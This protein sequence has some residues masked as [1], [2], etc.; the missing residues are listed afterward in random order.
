MT[1]GTAHQPGGRR[2]GRRHR[3]ALWRAGILLTMMAGV[4][5]ATASGVHSKATQRPSPAAATK[6]APTHPASVGTPY[7]V[8]SPGS[9]NPVGQSGSG[10]QGSSQQAGGRQGVGW[11][12][13][14]W[15]NHGSMDHDPAV[16]HSGSGSLRLTAPAGGYVVADLASRMAI[17]PGSHTYSAWIRTQ[18]PSGQQVCLDLLFFDD[19]GRPVG[20]DHNAFSLGGTHDWEHVSITLDT[21][22]GADRGD[23]QLRLSDQGLSQGGVAWFDDVAVAAP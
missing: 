7:S 6:G 23:L 22:V 14:G 2:R 8:P 11:Q 1:P 9:S 10:P 18:G 15:A 13:V 5:A 17:G 21:P 4:T 20:S 3:R 12:E 16:S 19:S